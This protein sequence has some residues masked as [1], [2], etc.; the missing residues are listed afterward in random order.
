MVTPLAASRVQAYSTDGKSL[1]DVMAEKVPAMQAQVKE[2]RKE[3]G[4][5]VVGNVT[6]DMVGLNSV[7]DN[8]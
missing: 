7:C 6:V 2:F 3:Y 5:T 1:K 4:K 8:F